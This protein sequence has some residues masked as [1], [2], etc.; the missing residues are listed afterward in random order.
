MVVN[1]TAK[2]MIGYDAEKSNTNFGMVYQ[3]ISDS[4]MSLPLNIPGTTYRKCLKVIL[5][6]YLLVLF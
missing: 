1:F 4:I 2:R 3:R 6:I 5:T